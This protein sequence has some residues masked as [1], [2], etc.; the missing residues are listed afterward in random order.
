MLTQAFTDLAANTRPEEVMARLRAVEDYCCRSE[1]AERGQ[2][3][4]VRG[5]VLNRLG[6]PSEALGDLHEA[7]QHFEKLGNRPDTAKIWQAIALVHSWRGEGRE[8]SLALLRVVAEAYDNPVNLALAL[9][10]AGRLEIEIGRPRD[11]CRFFCRGLDVGGEELSLLDIKRAK[12][13]TLQALVSSNQLAEAE[14]LLA[15]LNLDQ[16]TDRLRHLALLEQVRLALGRKRIEDV[17]QLLTRA[18]ALLPSEPDNF[19]HVEQGHVEAEVSFARKQYDEA[20]QQIGKVIAR[21]ASDDLAGREITARILQSRILDLLKNDEEADRTLAAALRR[22]TGRR[23]TGY[24]DMIREEFAVRG[25][26]QGVWLPGLNP[27]LLDLNSDGRFVRRRPL[28]E[29]GVGS[30]SRAYDLELG[31]EIVLKSMSLSRI[32]DTAAL[33]ARL[34]TARMEVAAASR[35]QHPGVGK[36]FGLLIE[37]NDDALL[38][39]ELVEGPTLREAMKGQL[40]IRETLGLLAQLAHSLTAIHAASIV[41]RDL[42]PENVVLRDNA[43]PVII[44]FGISAIGDFHLSAGSASTPNY[45]APEQR[46]GGWVDAKSDLYAFGVISYE[47]LVGHLPRQPLIGWHKVFGNFNRARTIKR[48]LRAASVPNSLVGLISSLLSGS[49]RRRPSL[50]RDVALKIQMSM[51]ETSSSQPKF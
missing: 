30:V 47:L 14:T 46:Y 18:S 13:N 43:F 20:L 12:I 11:A 8:A 40:H 34:E 15:S 50:A 48:E 49:A 51:T 35:V 22:A 36:V 1:G 37:P 10:E 26:S 32:Y 25:R 38:V 31:N 9:I 44:D 28:G 7:R 41:H 3:L 24:A 2:F 29:G 42:K 5:L 33:E 27:S 39:R 4:H 45:A 17:E 6:F 16:A 19:S 23:L 21:Y